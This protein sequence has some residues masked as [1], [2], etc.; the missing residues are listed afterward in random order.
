MKQ[1]QPCAGWDSML[2]TSHPEDLSFSDRARLMEHMAA[3]PT[4]ALTYDRYR[5]MDAI[6]CR[7]PATAPLPTLPPQ[8]L[9]L[10]EKEAAQKTAMRAASSGSRYRGSKG[11]SSSPQ[12]ET[13]QRGA[14]RHA[15]EVSFTLLSVAVLIIFSALLFHPYPRTTTGSWPTSS[16]VIPSN[17]QPTAKTTAT[18]QANATATSQ[19]A[20]ANATATAQTANANA[21]A[22]AQANAT[23]TAYATAV[24]NGAL[25]VN[26]TLQNNSRSYNWDTAS[27]QGGGGCAFIGGAYHVSMPQTG[28]ISACFAMSTNFSNFAYQIQMTIIIGDRGGIAFRADSGKGAF[29]YFYISTNGVYALEIYNNYTPSRPQPLSQGTSPAI[30]TGLNQTNLIAVVANG[31]SL[32]LFINM[33]LIAS[34][35][36][37]TYNSGKIGVVAEN[38]SNPTEVVFTNAKVWGR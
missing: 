29:Y 31:S 32:K 30:K 3:C 9:H 36:D 2:L 34:V 16:V 21:T 7:L 22:T 8:L 1:Q 6:L 23:A 11:N 28:F 12:L 15:L 38:I 14:F 26:D 37:S 5:D 35:S 17:S 24:A 20:I 13:A 33:Q 10:W 4:C 19:A 18:T 25:I 27:I